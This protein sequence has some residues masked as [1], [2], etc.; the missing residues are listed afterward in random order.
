VSEAYIERVTARPAFRKAHSDQI[1][2]FAKADTERAR[3]P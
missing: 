2:Q 1:A 3:R